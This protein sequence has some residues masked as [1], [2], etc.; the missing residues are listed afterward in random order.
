MKTI[1]IAW[2][3]K[4]AVKG[5]GRMERFDGVNYREAVE[6]DWEGHAALWLAKGTHEDERN[7]VIYAQ[8]EG[9]IAMTFE[10][11]DKDWREKAKAEAIKQAKATE[12]VQEMLR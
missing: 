1:V 11:N 10:T 8:R 4:T 3:T 7:A 12:R 6:L 5:T 2:A 9:K